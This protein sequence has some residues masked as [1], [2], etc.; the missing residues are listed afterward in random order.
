L[1]TG[2]ADR[3][4]QV[5]SQLGHVVRLLPTCSAE[6]SFLQPS[7]MMMTDEA[8]KADDVNDTAS[9]ITMHAPK[10]LPVRIERHRL[11]VA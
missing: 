11:S 5:I 9:C 1:L 7:T 3:Q 4:F 10:N 8:L 6:K 2:L